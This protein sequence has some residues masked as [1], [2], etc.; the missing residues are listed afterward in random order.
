[1][2][3]ALRNN[4]GSYVAIVVCGRVSRVMVRCCYDVSLMKVV[5]GMLRGGIEMIEWFF[6]EKY[7]YEDSLYVIVDVIIKS[8]SDWVMFDGGFVVML[9]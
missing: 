3:T 1:M 8:Y 6:D 9:L 2:V 7:E 5:E 4:S